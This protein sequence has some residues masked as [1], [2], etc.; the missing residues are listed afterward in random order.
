MSDA[1]APVRIEVHYLG[2]VTAIALDKKEVDAWIE[3][4]VAFAGRRSSRSNADIIGGHI[5]LNLRAEGI[6]P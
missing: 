6:T 3:D 2:E 1:T 5:E 4:K